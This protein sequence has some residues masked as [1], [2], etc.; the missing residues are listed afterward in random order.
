VLFVCPSLCCTKFEYN[1]YMCLESDWCECVSTISNPIVLD[2]TVIM[3]SEEGS[4]LRGPVEITT[5]TGALKIAFGH[6]VVA[7]RKDKADPSN[8]CEFYFVGVRQTPC[9]SGG[10]RLKLLLASADMSN[11]RI[12][13]FSWL[14]RVR[15]SKLSV[16]KRLTLRSLL[17]S[18]VVRKEKA[19]Q[20]P[21]LTSPRTLRKRSNPPAAS[22]TSPAPGTKRRKREKKKQTQKAKE[23]TPSQRIPAK[24]KVEAFSED[25]EGDETDIVDFRGRRCDKRENKSTS[26]IPSQPLRME[27]RHR[28]FSSPSFHATTSTYAGISSSSSSSSL[29]V[30]TNNE[31]STGIRTCIAGATSSS[32]PTPGSAMHGSVSSSSA[33]PGCSGFGMHGREALFSSSVG[34]RGSGQHT[35]TCAMSCGGA[36]NSFLIPNMGFYQHVYPPVHPHPETLRLQL[37][38]F[39]QSQEI[40]RLRREEREQWYLNQQ[41]RFNNA[42]ESAARSMQM[43]SSSL[44][45][46]Q[47][48][49]MQSTTF[50]P[51]I[52]NAPNTQEQKEN[53]FGSY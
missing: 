42:V 28:Q 33:S 21:I 25:R 17:I 18:H 36:L 48:P 29:N 12:G 24:N 51:T 14:L 45:P 10:A 44:F 31:E 13:Q 27:L 43:F 22:I 7:S 15:F 23:D 1:L 30:S 5:P 39:Y 52:R 38:N 34:V 9:S 49:Q 16:A 4:F 19:L 3:K 35:C 50:M 6:K 47:P 40:E 26:K 53:L 20:Q 41:L 32:A 8:G 37:I 2:S 46:P 11:C